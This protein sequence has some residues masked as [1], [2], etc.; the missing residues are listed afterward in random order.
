MNKRIARA[1]ALILALAMVFV[2]ASIA[3]AAEE[4]PKYG[5]TFVVGVASDPS[6]LNGTIS[7][8]FNDKIVSSNIYSMLIRLDYGMN[9]VPDLA[10]SWD[11]SEDGLT[12]TFHLR[13]GVKWHDGEPFTSADVKFTM[14][15]SILKYHPRAD[16]FKSVLESVEAPD[17]N[18][19]VFH[20]QKKYGAFMNALAYDVFVIPKHIYEGT[21]VKEN[22]A[23]AT[24][25]GTG[26][27][28]F[29]E[30]NRGSHIALKA[31]P[32]YFVE[33]QP[34]LDKL[35]FRIIPDASSRVLALE[36]GEVDYLAYQALP[37]SAVSELEANA[38]IAIT[39]EGFESLGTILMLTFNMDEPKL[40]DAKVRRAIAEAIDRAYI[41]EHADYGL[42]I[43]ATSTFTSTSWAYNPDV[44]KYDYDVE[45][46]KALLDEAGLKPDANGT[47]LT[48]RLTCDANVELNRKAGEI[49]KANLAEVGIQVDYE[50]VE[51]SVMLD[52]V[53]VS[54]D[55]DMQIHGFS[56]GS[57]PSIDVAR[58]YLTSN[59]R[60]VN[61]TNGAGYS[62]P[63][64]DELFKKG[65]E[66][67]D[68]N[69]RAG[70]YKDVQKIL[71]DEL[72]I[73]WLEEQGLV[74]AYNAKFHNVHSWSAYSYYIFWDVWSDDGVAPAAPAAEPASAEPAPA[75]EAAPAAPAAPEAPAAKS[76][77]TPVIVIAVIAVAVVAAAVIAKKRGKKEEDED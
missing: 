11:I 35:I 43:P 64:V 30:W 6:T 8:S 10:E 24:P 20:L 14:E 44:A 32:N 55:F 69:E 47:R 3:L 4:Q 19:V 40:Q 61:F 1:L 16:N 70:Y 76:S 65:G 51:R 12:Y 5:G 31:N 73:V 28:V 60:P 50:P 62:N 18:T 74:A 54:R 71:C 57:D 33:G 77:A 63:E 38:N 26:P 53:Y 68:I 67:S 37:S 25:V 13:Q 39:H 7:G 52:R 48:L 27:F 42:G 66:A 59:I 58:F 22:P 72:P 17:D 21:D 15:E 29:E 45:A 23:N 56:T 2:T 36:T 75:G 34:Y 49:I 9:P 41:V 46:S